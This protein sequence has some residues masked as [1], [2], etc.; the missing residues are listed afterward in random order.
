MSIGVHLN[1]KSEIYHCNIFCMM[2]IL[3]YSFTAAYCDDFF[4]LSLCF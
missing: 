2:L 3:L 1:Q 4:L